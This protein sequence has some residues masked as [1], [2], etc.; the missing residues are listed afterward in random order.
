MLSSM[1]GVI[2]ALTL[3]G[4]AF[5]L[6]EGDSPAVE[7][8]HSTCLARDIPDCTSCLHKVCCLHLRACFGLNPCSFVKV[9]HF[10]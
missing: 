9:R 4:F 3:L 7:V 1:A 10:Y 6:A 8:A 5:S 2:A